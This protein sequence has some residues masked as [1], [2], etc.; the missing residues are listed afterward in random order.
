MATRIKNPKVCQNRPVVIC[1]DSSNGSFPSP[2]RYVHVYCDH[3]TANQK[4]GTTSKTNANI[5]A[6]ATPY[7]KPTSPTSRPSVILKPGRTVRIAAGRIKK[8]ESAP[9]ISEA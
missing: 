7:P 2:M 3:L 4:A 9:K 8:I 1:H 5:T 6:M